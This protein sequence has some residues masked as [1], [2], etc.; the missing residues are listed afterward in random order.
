MSDSSGITVVPV[1]NQAGSAGKTTTVVTL[2]A[3]LAEAG[4]RVLVVDL[5]GQANATAWLG[6]NPDTVTTT[7]G[8][9]MLRRRDLADAVVPTNTP[10]VRLVPSSP[11]MDAAAVELSRVTGGE[12]RLRLALVD[13]TDVDVVLLDCP[14]ALSVVT[15][16]AMVAATAVVTVTAP[17]AKELAGVPRLE[18]TVAEVAEA[19]NPQLM[20]AGI[21]PC[22]V[23]SNA[24][25]LYAEALAMLTDAYPGITTPS[26]RRSV[27]APEAYAQEVPLPAHAPR[28]PVTDD[29]RAVLGYLQGKGVLP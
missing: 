29:Y 26:V 19:Y 15:I 16:A 14:G 13:V 5:D 27:R 3:L 25:A 28:E 6:V 10:G 2:A 17:T 11:E 18:E 1:A 9:V 21:V 20:L 7:A 12:Q 4:R 24:G 23:P 8:D 22:I